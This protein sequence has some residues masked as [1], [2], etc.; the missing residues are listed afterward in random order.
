MDSLGGFKVGDKVRCHLTE[1]PDDA[2]EYWIVD[3]AGFV[4]TV[5]DFCAG[6]QKFAPRWDALILSDGNYYRPH[7]LTL[8][9]PEFKVGDRVKV[10]KRG[11]PG[12]GPGWDPVMEQNVG[13]SG[14]VTGIHDKG[15]NWLRVKVD[16]GNNN[17]F[18]GS[19]GQG[20]VYPVEHLSKIPDAP[21]VNHEPRHGTVLTFKDGNLTACGPADKAIG[22]LQKHGTVEDEDMDEHD[23]LL[24]LRA[25]RDSERRWAAHW[26]GVAD[27][28]ED[29]FKR[30]TEAELVSA[31][32]GADLDNAENV[33]ALLERELQNTKVQRDG[34]IEE[35]ARSKKDSRQYCADAFDAETSRDR[36]LRIR[37]MALFVG[38]SCV[39]SAGYVLYSLWGVI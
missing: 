21:K 39:G 28:R 11:E 5:E 8:V 19:D 25:E 13:R 3:K 18:Y 27:S 23:E 12:V 22:V 9:T 31:R 24:T 7:W 30:A 29:Q 6:G 38:A 32:L 37:N 35:A 14:V 36:A 34:W 4:G 15:K 16:G 1:K 2:D 26:K 33:N 17:F 10:E 20:W